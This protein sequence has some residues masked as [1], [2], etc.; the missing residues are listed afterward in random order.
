MKQIKILLIA[1][2]LIP[3]LFLFTAE[4][5]AEQRSVEGGGKA[6]FN[7]EAYRG[8]VVLLDFWASWCGPCREAFPWLNAMQR[9]Y[10]GLGLEVIGINLDLSREEADQFLANTPAEFTLHYDPE[11]MLAKRYDLQGMP[12]SYL[13]DRKGRLLITHTGFFKSETHQRELEIRQ[14]LRP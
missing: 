5:S 9:K 1:V 6:E 2:I 14:A 4:T 7:L 12:A 13:F 8:K 10:Q 3:V 11:G